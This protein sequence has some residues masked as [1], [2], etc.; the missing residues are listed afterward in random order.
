MRFILASAV[1]RVQN[2]VPLKQAEQDLLND[3]GMKYVCAKFEVDK[4]Q[5]VAQFRG[6]LKC[7][8]SITS[9]HRARK[10]TLKKPSSSQKKKMQ[11][12]YDSSVDYTNHRELQNYMQAK[13]QSLLYSIFINAFSDA[14]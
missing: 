11:N 14:A 8:P 13:V 3:K 2:S 10:N 7:H 5:A 12:I 9:V 1:E 4:E 6:D